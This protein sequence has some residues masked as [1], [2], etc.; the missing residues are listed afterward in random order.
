MTRS[1]TI[2]VLEP[3]PQDPARCKPENPDIIVA[4]HAP[5]PALVN[6]IWHTDRPWRSSWTTA[7][8]DLEN[9]FLDA[10]S[11]IRALVD[12]VDA[13]ALTGLMLYTQSVAN[14]PPE[15]WSRPCY[16]SRDKSDARRLKL[17]QYSLHYW[18]REISSYEEK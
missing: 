12:P 10:F 8:E 18:F 13:I 6:R 2:F 4:D 5:L 3:P 15:E 1:P 9:P 17:D 14:P 7:Y 16:S 11:S